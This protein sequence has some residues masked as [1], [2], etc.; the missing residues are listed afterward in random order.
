[1]YMVQYKNSFW[2]LAVS[3]WNFKANFY[4]LKKFSTFTCQANSVFNDGKVRD[5]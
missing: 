3:A 1:M 5:I 4:T 2:L